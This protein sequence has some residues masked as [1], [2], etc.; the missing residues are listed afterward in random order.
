[1]LRTYLFATSLRVVLLPSPP[2]SCER[3][4]RGPPTLPLSSSL[5]PRKHQERSRVLA[6]GRRDG[7]DSSSPRF[8]CPPPPPAAQHH[9]RRPAAPR[10]AI[11][12]RTHLRR[13]PEASSQRSAAR[14]RTSHTGRPGVPVARPNPIC[15]HAAGSSISLFRSL[16]VCFLSP[17]LTSPHLTHTPRARVGPRVT[18][19]AA[20]H[21]GGHL[22]CNQSA[23]PCSTPSGAAAAAASSS[24]GSRR[25]GRTTTTTSAITTYNHPLLGH[26][27]RPLRL[28]V[29]LRLP[30]ARARPPSSRPLPP[31]AREN[32][33]AFA[34]TQPV[35]PEPRS[36]NS[37]PPFPRLST[38]THARPTR[39]PM[40]P[41]SPVP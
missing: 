41:M 18:R 23:P 38:R 36:S 17:H 30:R 39:L 12:S 24:S 5:F 6:P 11:V 13:A 37:H 22:P 3:A 15:P 21:S 32:R 4:G 34:V 27:H 33:S 7:P 14:T 2:A 20:A 26:N 8:G 1:M 9:G 16:L 31:P 25:R 10:P 29:S 40:P 35:W 28:Y 19:R